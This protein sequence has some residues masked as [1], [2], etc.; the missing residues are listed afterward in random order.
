[1]HRRHRD[2]PLFVTFIYFHAF[3]LCNNASLAC[4]PVPT[5]FLSVPFFLAPLA[6]HF[7]P[8]EQ[9]NFTM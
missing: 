7:Y 9:D 1:M 3:F 2:H 4:V 5:N 6:Y 8:Y